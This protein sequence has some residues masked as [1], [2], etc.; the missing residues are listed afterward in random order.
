MV[1]GS[2]PA[3]IHFYNL[4][5]QIFR[6]FDEFHDEVSDFLGFSHASG[7]DLI[8]KHRMFFLGEKTVHLGVDRAAGDRVDLDAARRK[9]LR[10]GARH[11]VDAAFGGRIGD[12]AGSA[13]DAP[14]GG[15]IDDLSAVV[16]DH[17]GDRK[18]GAV[19]DG[20]EIR[21]DDPVPVLKAQVL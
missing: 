4:S 14:D 18:F 15:D 6:C 3:T 12:F 17:P 8:Q 10:E 20:G 13:A 2:D 1:A 7:R 16:V 19:E 21:G 9:F 11:G 5:G